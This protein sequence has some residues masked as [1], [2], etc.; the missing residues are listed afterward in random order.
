[1][2]VRKLH[3]TENT[4]R[5]SGQNVS[6]YAASNS[7]TA[8]MLLNKSHSCRSSLCHGLSSRESEATRV[9]GRQHRTPGTRTASPVL[10]ALHNA[11]AERPSV[12]TLRRRTD[13]QRAWIPCVAASAA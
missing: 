5:A 13:K 10:N 1:M 8:K 12:Q 6:I 7:T 3:H 11:A 9:W 4:G 2:A